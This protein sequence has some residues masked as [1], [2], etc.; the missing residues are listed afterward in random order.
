MIRRLLHALFCTACRDGYV[1]RT[2]RAIGIEIANRPWTRP[3]G[4]LHREP[5]DNA[6]RR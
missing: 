6:G 5:K 4:T 3:E 1:C 2:G